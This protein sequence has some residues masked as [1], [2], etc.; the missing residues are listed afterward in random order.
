MKQELSVKSVVAIGIGSAIFVILGRFASVP[1][2]IPNT[3]LETTYPFLAFF[4]VLFGPL[5][6]FLTDFIGHTLKDL[7]SYGNPWWSW[8]ICSG[9]IGAFF[10]LI[11][12][13]LKITQGRFTTKDII[14]FNLSQILANFL[15]WSLFAPLLDILIYSEPANKVF[16]QGAIS[17]LSNSL[18]V[19]ILGTLLIKAYASSQTKKGSLRKE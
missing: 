10:G 11:G 3:N 12:K 18:S 7:I 6:G 13:H 17:A 2:G 1:T 15:T 9:I 16:L 19:G 5:V 4:A 14:L 8:V